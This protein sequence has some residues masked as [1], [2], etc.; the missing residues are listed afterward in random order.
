MLQN[1]VELDDGASYTHLF[2]TLYLMSASLC[3]PVPGHALTQDS[4]IQEAPTICIWSMRT[5]DRGWAQVE[6]TTNR[7]TLKRAFDEI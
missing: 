3:F 6:I 1:I 5:W 4:H 7:A 2:L